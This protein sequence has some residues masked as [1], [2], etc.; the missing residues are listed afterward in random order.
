MRGGYSSSLKLNDERRMDGKK[1]VT[2]RGEARDRYQLVA[3]LNGGVMVARLLPLAAATEDADPLEPRLLH[4]HGCPFASL[5]LSLLRI[6]F[7]FLP[8]PTRCCRLSSCG[9]TVPG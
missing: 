1:Y 5:S 4:R 8:I 7:L 2:D 3:E 6:R 9:S